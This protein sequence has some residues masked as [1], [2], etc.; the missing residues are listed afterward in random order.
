[1]SR[2]CKV[3]NVNFAFQRIVTRDDDEGF[4]LIELLIVIV[5]LGIMGTVVVFSVTGITDRGQE[6]ACAQ[7]ARTLATAVEAYFAQSGSATIPATGT[8]PSRYERTL[9]DAGL[10][11][12]MSEYWDVAAEGYLAGVSPC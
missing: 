6:N 12:G 7:D 4:S 10:S 1:M 5:V 3:I 9:V 11:R 2:S 8:G